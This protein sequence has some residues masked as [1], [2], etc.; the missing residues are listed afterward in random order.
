MRLDFIVSNKLRA[1]LIINSKF[2]RP[3]IRSK[4]AQSLNFVLS[5]RAVGGSY[6]LGGVQNQYFYFVSIVAK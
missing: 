2:T 3:L 4:A 6:N 5:S 1:I